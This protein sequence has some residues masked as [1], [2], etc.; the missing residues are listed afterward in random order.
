MGELLEDVK[1]AQLEDDRRRAHFDSLQK[2]HCRAQEDGSTQHGP[3]PSRL[4]VG[5]PLVVLDRKNKR[6]DGVVV[7]VDLA[8]PARTPWTWAGQPGYTARFAAGQWEVLTKGGAWLQSAHTAVS[9]SCEPPRMPLAGSHATGDGS[10]VSLVRQYEGMLWRGDSP[11]T[12]AG[13]YITG[14]ATAQPGLQHGNELGVAQ[15]KALLA[16]MGKYAEVAEADFTRLAY[17]PPRATAYPISV[18]ETSELSKGIAASRPY[19]KHELEQVEVIQACC[20]LPAHPPTQPH[21]HT[22]LACMHL[23]GV[24]AMDEGR[25]RCAMLDAFE[26]GHVPDG[27][28]LNKKT[29]HRGGV[30]LQDGARVLEKVLHQGGGGCVACALGA[31]PLVPLL[32]PPTPEWAAC[33]RPALRH[34]ESGLAHPPQKRPAGGEV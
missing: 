16:S 15:E 26:D 4:M 19:I 10:G 11:P 21:T 13:S 32:L 30:E 34:P 22:P 20:A 5:D 7:W 23:F 27:G 2:P 9:G 3:V 1:Q 12:P 24:G 8:H 18:E 25:S 33:L 29:A 31:H 6:C 14:D 17:M 28:F